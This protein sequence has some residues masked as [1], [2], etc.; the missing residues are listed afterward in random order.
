MAA[1]PALTARLDELLA[2]FEKRGMDLPAGLFTRRTEFRLNGTPF[3]SL[4]GRSPADPLILM[5]ARGPAGYRLAIKGLQHAV[6]DAV[7]ERGELT[8]VAR[9][10]R[11]QVT[12]QVWL[13]GHLRGTGEALE[14]VI[15]VTLDLA[16]EGHVDVASAVVAEPALAALRAARVR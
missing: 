3:E 10:G 11:R 7:V 14:A 4:L 5:L 8:E 13:S 6:P 1:D 2:L 12:G 9:D 16:D 15:D